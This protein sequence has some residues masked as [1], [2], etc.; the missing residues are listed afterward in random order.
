MRIVFFVLSFLLLSSNVFSQF[1]DSLYMAQEDTLAGYL[2][3][4]RDARD[5]SVRN[6]YVDKAL[7]MFDTVMYDWESIY[8]LFDNLPVEKS[9]A[10]DSSLR[11]FSWNYL[12]PGGRYQYHAVVQVYDT[13][14]HYYNYWI[15]KDVR[16]LDTSIVTDTNWYGALY[17]D[18][19]SYEYRENVFYTL[20][21]VDFNDLFISK[22]II[23][24]LRIDYENGRLL[25]GAPLFFRESNWHNRIVFEYSARVSMTLRYNEELEMI[26]YDNLEPRESRYRGNHEFYGPD[27]TFSGLRLRFGRWDEVKNIDVDPDTFK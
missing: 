5:T 17:Y 10:S 18:I 19:I 1:H 7:D 20:L 6:Y 9:Y 14:R 27:M 11:I 22:R 3:N 16:K 8:F 2:I 15:L 23:D 24:M 12:L 25:F 13:V 4:A 21:G 26:I